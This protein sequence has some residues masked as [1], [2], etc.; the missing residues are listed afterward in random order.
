MVMVGLPSSIVWSGSISCGLLQMNV[1]GN[2][3]EKPELQRLKAELE[4]RAQKEFEEKLGEVNAY[5]VE[6][7]KAREQIDRIRDSNEMEIRKEFERMKKDLLVSRQAASI[8]LIFW[9]P[10]YVIWSCVVLA[11]VRYL[12]ITGSSM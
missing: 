9:S 6:Q 12:E 8:V 2:Y 1:S 11:R 10:F 4:A 7:A 5:L 3:A